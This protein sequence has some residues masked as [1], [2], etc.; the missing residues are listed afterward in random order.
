MIQDI[1]YLVSSF[2]SHSFTHVR[3]QGNNVAYA[4]TWWAINS[5]NLTVWMEDVLPNIQ[6]VVQVDLAYVD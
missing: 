4:L 6:S 3:C 2:I 5:S 1:R